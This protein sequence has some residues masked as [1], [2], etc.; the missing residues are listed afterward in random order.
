VL[1]DVAIVRPERLTDVDMLIVRENLGGVYAGEFG[2][3]EGGRIAYQTFAYHADQVERIV[4]VAARLAVTRRGLLT[5]TGKAG[6]VPEVSAL[7]RR[8][9]SRWRPSTGWRPTSSRSTTR[10][11]S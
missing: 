11:I 4:Q 3:R 6:G 7:W 1:A 9:P 5:V 10:A 8:W 2:R